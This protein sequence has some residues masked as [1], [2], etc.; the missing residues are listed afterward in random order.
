MRIPKKVNRFCP[1]CRKHQEHKVKDVSSGQ[2]R[3]S[4]KRGGKKRVKK[5]GDWRGMGNKGKYSS[6]VT[7][8]KTKTTK[9]TNIRYT[10]KECGKSHYQKKGKRSGKIEVKQRGKP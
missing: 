3:G 2:K 4:L 7:K 1:S 6:G 9:K 5:R 8:R 10:C